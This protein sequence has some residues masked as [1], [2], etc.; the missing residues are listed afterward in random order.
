[1]TS[2]Y[3]RNNELV[4]VLKIFWS[5]SRKS[6]GLVDKNTLLKQKSPTNNQNITRWG[7]LK[8]VEISKQ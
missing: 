4:S 6:I 1:V 3:L 7:F 5:C 8:Q 2:Q